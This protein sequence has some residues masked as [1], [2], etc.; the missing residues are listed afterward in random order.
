MSA[1]LEMIR[2]AAAPHGLNLVGAVSVARYDS[3]VKE[4]SRAGAID[5]AARSIAI[6]GNGGGALWRAFQRHLERHPGWFQRENPLDDFTR[7]VIER[8]VATALR[9]AGLRCTIIYPFMSSGPTLNFIELAK[10]AGIAG[11]SILG[12]AVHPVY[13]PW[14]AFRGAILLNEVI[15]SPGEAAGFD[16]CPRCT[17]RSCIP[18]CPVG[19]ISVAAGWDIPECLTHRVEVEPDC[20]PRCHARAGCVLG[21]EHRYPDDELAYHQMRS[22]RAMRPYYE[23]HLKPSCKV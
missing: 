16:P 1:T 15:D 3:A 5:P 20:A 8:D 19:A 22:L 13:G 12:V 23:T 4:V 7:E 10:I 2:R 21:P 18:A 17:V 11:P 14:I 9:G 6:V